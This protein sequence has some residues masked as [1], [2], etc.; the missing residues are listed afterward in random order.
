MNVR[1]PTKQ[2]KEQAEL[3]DTW[4]KGPSEFQ[5]FYEDDETCLILEGNAEVFDA[6]GYSISFG[7]GD[8]VTFEKGLHCTWKINRKILKRYRLG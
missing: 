3:W 5:W 8:W 2:E 7:S 6:R 1:K 4:S